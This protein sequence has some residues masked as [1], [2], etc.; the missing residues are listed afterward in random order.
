MRAGLLDRQAALAVGERLLGPRELVLEPRGV[1]VDQRRGQRHPLAS[2]VHTLLRCQPFLLERLV[3]HVRVDVGHRAGFVRQEPLDAGLRHPPV[4]QLGLDRAPSRR[5]RARQ[6]HDVR[7]R[8]PQPRHE[9]AQIRDLHRV[10]GQLP[11]REEVP[12]QLKSCAYARTVFGERSIRCR[13]RKNP[14]ADPTSLPSMASTVHASRPSGNATRWA[15]CEEVNADRS[16][17]RG[18]RKARS[19][20][21]TA[22]RPRAQHRGEGAIHTA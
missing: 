16:V 12:E 9:V 13:Y 20:H 6:R 18:C 4:D 15:I 21:A 5:G 19:A 22:L 8:A 3:E 17:T 1:V 11:A 7:R 10:P 14:A 2:G